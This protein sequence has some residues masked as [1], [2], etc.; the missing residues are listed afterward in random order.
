ML[1]IIPLVL[2]FPKIWVLLAASFAGED[3]S[4][5]M[6]L[7]LIFLLSQTSHNGESTKNNVDLNKR[8]LVFNILIMTD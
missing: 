4:L 3:S 8:D 7:K 6:S 1:H 5:V 2:V